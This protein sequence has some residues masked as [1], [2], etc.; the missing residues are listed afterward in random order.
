MRKTF[1]IVTTSDE[2]GE[3]SHDLTVHPSTTSNHWEF[4]TYYEALTKAKLLCPPMVTA[5]FDGKEVATALWAAVDAS[6][7][8]GAT[9][10]NDPKRHDIIA[11]HCAMTRNRV[12]ALLGINYAGQATDSMK[13][14]L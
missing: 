4:K 2:N 14:W 10:N 5:T 11:S 6:Q 13:R 7:K 12:M 3:T 9:G 8:L 1:K